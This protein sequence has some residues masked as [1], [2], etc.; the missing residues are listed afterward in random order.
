MDEF[1]RLKNIVAALRHPQTGCPW[2]LKQTPVSLL[3]NFVEELYEAVEAIEK[4]DPEHIKEELGDLLLHI[5]MQARLAEE[6]RN[7]AVE[8]AARGIADKLIRR[9]PH[10]FGEAQAEGAEAVKVNWE[11]IKQKEKAQRQSALDGIP[12]AMPALITA[13]RMQEKAASV[14]FDWN[15]TEPIYAKIQEETAE[16]REAV[17]IGR[18]EHIQEELGDLLF[19]VVNLA[20]QLKVDAETAL[21][22]TIDKFERRFH[23]VEQSVKEEGKQPAQCS[24]EELDAHW[25]KA[26]RLGL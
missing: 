7:F 19:A 15:D 11:R 16:L 25:E 20:R 8:D 26:K 12:K 5:F 10:V 2:D 13:W 22:G 17:A 3:P 1:T 24:L 6:N 21:R 9:H 4:G 23:F 18:Q 14:G